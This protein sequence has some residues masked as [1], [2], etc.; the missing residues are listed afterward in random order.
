MVSHAGVCVCS[1]NE[2]REGKKFWVG[3][4]FTS[5]HFLVGQLCIFDILERKDGPVMEQ[6][7][8]KRHQVTKIRFNPSLPILAAADSRGHVFSMKV[9]DHLQNPG[10]VMDEEKEVQQLLRTLRVMT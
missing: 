6:Q 4:R 3:F 8:V 5:A 9:P 2:F 7:L 10:L 1:C